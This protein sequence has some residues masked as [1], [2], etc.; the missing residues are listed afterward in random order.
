MV[1]VVLAASLGLILWGY[2]IVGT[3]LSALVCLLSLPH[4]YRMYR[5]GRT[6]DY[7]SGSSFGRPVS[8]DRYILWGLVALGLTVYGALSI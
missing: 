2:P 3:I 5:A 7:G 8:A 6:F 1:L 4:G